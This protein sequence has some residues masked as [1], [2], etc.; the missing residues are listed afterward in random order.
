[1]VELEAEAQHLSQLMETLMV[2]KEKGKARRTRH[3][4]YSERA[5]AE[6]SGEID[7]KERER[8][9]EGYTSR[10]EDESWSS[11]EE[12]SSEEDEEDGSVE[13]VPEPAAA[14]SS[15]IPQDD[16]SS[17]WFQELGRFD[18]ESDMP[19][20]LRLAAQGWRQ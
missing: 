18:M 9:E 15:S 12:S 16:C 8:E 20:L 6:K 17:Q 13:P 10:G 1:M 4:E 14:V 2:L 5:K 11:D 3:A 7:R 19:R